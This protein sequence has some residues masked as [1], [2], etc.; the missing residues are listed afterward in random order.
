M[1]LSWEEQLIPWEDIN[2]RLCEVHKN[3]FT[4]GKL[5]V[6]KIGGLPKN[7]ETQ[8]R[9]TNMAV[10]NLQESSSFLLVNIHTYEKVQPE[11]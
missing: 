5:D 3:H 4:A 11:T 7:I 9:H 1:F 10:P 8:R 6:L 2:H